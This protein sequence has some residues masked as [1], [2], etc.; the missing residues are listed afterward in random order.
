VLILGVAVLLAFGTFIYLVMTRATRAPDAA[1][2]SPPVAAAETGAWGRL[3]L[4][5]PAGTRIQA[6][7][8][9]GRLAIVQL[10]TGTPGTD[11]RLVVFD[12]HQGRILGTVTLGAR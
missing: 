5:Q 10:Y 7:T 1:A 11:E 3:L 6:V 12:P 8:A 2:P 4:D 9:H